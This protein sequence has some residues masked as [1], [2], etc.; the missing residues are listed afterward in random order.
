MV[1]NGKLELRL[2]QAYAILR[3]DYNRMNM[4]TKNAS[5]LCSARGCGRDGRDALAEHI[6]AQGPLAV[7]TVADPCSCGSANACTLE[8]QG[9]R[10]TRS[11]G[12][13]RRVC[14]ISPPK[15]PTCVD[16]ISEV[17]GSGGWI[18]QTL[19]LGWFTNRLTL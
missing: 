7:K 1:M 13:W 11:E 16:P 14:K 3:A 4:K 9:F 8:Q 10:A 6:V 19:F 2:A 17:G 18:F 15:G 12:M 5:R